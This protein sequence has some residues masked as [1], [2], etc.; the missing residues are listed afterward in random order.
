MAQNDPWAEFRTGPAQTAPAMP[1]SQDPIIKPADPYKPAAEQ[2]AQADQRMQEEKFTWERQRAAQVDSKKSATEIDIAAKEASGVKRANTV[3]A[4]LG[5]VRDLY[6]QDIQGQP[7]ERA[8]GATEYIPILPDN[9]R[10]TAAGNAILPLIRPLVAQSAKEGDS[11][12]EMMVFQAYIPAAGDSDQTIEEKMG[13]LEMLIGGMVDGKPASQLLEENGLRV[14]EM[15]L[16]GSVTDESG[17][18]PPPP[19]GSGGGGGMAAIGA[20]VGDILQ[21][22]GN[23]AGIIGNPLNAT[24]NA[25][26]GTN[27]STDLGRT[28]RGNLPQ[29]NPVA[30]A[31]IQG[32]TAAL[33]GA[34]A[35]RAV[36]PLLQAGVPQNALLMLGRTPVADTA[37]GAG[38][39]LGS[40]IA[41]RND[42]GPAGQIAGALIG[43]M[44]GYGGARALANV[45]APRVASQAAQAAQRQGVDLLPADLGG[46]GTKIL[47]SGA[48]ASPLSAGPI[49]TQARK[50]VGQVEQAS[51]RAARSQGASMTTDK[52]GETI[53]GAAEKY[54]AGTRQ[55]GESLYDRAYQAAGRVKTIKP[56]RTVQAIDDQI[57]RLG[58]EPTAEARALSRELAEFR[59]SIADGVSIQGLRDARTRLS[60]GLYDGQMRSSTTQGMY[61]KIL[62]NVANDIDAGLRSV[63]KDK[64]ADIFRRADSFWSGR[65]EHIDEVLQPLIGKGTQKG[66]EQI[67]QTIESMAR[68]QAGGNARLSRVLAEMTPQEAGQVRATIIDRIG[69]A[70]PGQQDATGEAFSAGSFLTNWAKMTPQAKASLFSDKGLRQNLNDIAVIAE[71]MKATQSMANFSNT[72]M[73]VTGGGQSIGAVAIGAALHPLVAAVIGGG[74]YATGKLLA[75]PGFARWLAKAPKT[76][77]PAAIRKYS[78]GLGV[79][80]GREPLIANDAKALQ[81]YLQQSF[82]QSPVRAAAS[83]E[84]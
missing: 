59:D 55:R 68:G 48:K 69:R 16:T 75:S 32:G 49:R 36:S 47:T 52:A 60:S 11:D 82:S 10:F 57:A 61:K 13:M 34:G 63:G 54:V 78:E 74:Q 39:G 9:E 73:A 42:A 56:A 28:L 41:L 79:L 43:G 12:K 31:I 62:G 66:G 72:A 6:K 45:G 40:E 21:G 44:A 1:R 8:F 18:P 30:G 7:I 33:S 35:A 76:Q 37:A 5:R 23:V 14:G 58:N 80:A 51:D 19:G 3:N 83:E 17:S 22:A 65:V 4:I 2:R 50:A 46:T 53:R 24:I 25:A 38:A 70:T 15:G 27:L 84:E 67:V 64:A 71:N 20:G 29:G 77:N 26:F 81:Q